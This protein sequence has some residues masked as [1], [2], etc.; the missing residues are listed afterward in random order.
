MTNLN[1]KDESNCILLAEVFDGPKNRML[2][3]ERKRKTNKRA[4]QKRKEERCF[5]RVRDRY[6]TL[7]YTVK[8]FFFKKVFTNF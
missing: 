8:K 7:Y 4:V 1:Y 3:N 2:E 6:L 5:Q